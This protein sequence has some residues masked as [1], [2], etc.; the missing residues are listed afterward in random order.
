MGKYQEKSSYGK[1]ADTK[2]VAAAR[3]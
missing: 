2:S 1:V 3:E